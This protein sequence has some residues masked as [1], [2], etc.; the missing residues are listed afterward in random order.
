MSDVDR[1]PAGPGWPTNGRAHAAALAAALPDGLLQLDAATG[2]VLAVNPAAEALLGYEATALQ[3]Q[4]GLLVDRVH[5][6]DRARGRKLGAP[7]PEAPTRGR[8]R[9][10]RPDGRVSWLE[11]HGAVATDDT[12]L[13]VLREVTAAERERLLVAT[14]LVLQTTANRGGGQLESGLRAAGYHLVDHLDAGQLRIVTTEPADLD[15]TVRP[16]SVAVPADAPTRSEPLRRGTEEVGTLTVSWPPPLQPGPEQTERLR[17][18]ARELAGTIGQALSRDQLRLQRLVLDSTVNGVVVTDAQ[19][20]ILWVNDAI[21]TQTGFDRP[22]LIGAT[23]N[24]WRSGIHGPEVYRELWETVL[25]GDVWRGELVN[26]HAD[27]SLRLVRLTI[28]PIQ[29]DGEVEQL[30]AVHDDITEQRAAEEAREQADRQLR[31][32]L[33][34]L[35]VVVA[36]LDDEACIQRIDGA[37][38][39]VF[40]LDRDDL[41]GRPLA[42][43][44]PAARELTDALEAV[45][46]GGQV[47][48]VTRLGSRS[49]SL[50]LRPLQDRDER[51]P[52]TFVL[53]TDVT[54]REQ[55]VR[56]IRAARAQLELLVATTTDLMLLIDDADRVTYANPAG[57]LILGRPTDQLV[58]RSL[59]TLLGETE[60]AERSALARALDGGSDAT[61]HLGVQRPDGEHRHLD[62]VVADLRDDPGI[63]VAIL[64]GRDL[65]DTLRSAELRE[66]HRRQLEAVNAELAQASRARDDLL[67]VTSHELR[68]PLTPILGF[69]EMLLA[70]DDGSLGD[71][72]RHL[73]EV[74]GRNATRM[75]RLVDDLL[76]VS[77]L[78][79]GAVRADRHPTTLRRVVDEVVTTIGAELGTITVTGDAEVVADPEHLT[80]VLFNLLVN[81]RRYGA[82]PVELRIESGPAEVVVAVEDRGP[83]VPESFVPLMFDRF[84]QASTGDRRTAGG[85]GLGLTIVQALV[86]ANGGVVRYRR[87]RHAGACFEVVLPAPGQPTVTDPVAGGVQAAGEDAADPRR[88]HPDMPGTDDTAA[89]DTR[90]DL[91]PI[92]RAMA[93][94]TEELSDARTPAQLVQGLLHAV[95]SLGGWVVPADIADEHAL[96]LQVDLGVTSPM[97]VAAEVHHPARRLLEAHLP[98]LVVAAQA[99]LRG[100][101][102]DV[103]GDEPS[104]RGRLTGRR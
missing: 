20:T 59:W 92:T 84:A 18:A 1:R 76:L 74:I 69:V 21:L 58:G 86:A 31:S 80:R 49:V 54:A 51:P 55:A 15:L 85:S 10:L 44:L 67:S 25:A 95:R 43:L 77:R 100:L 101:Q 33:E 27:G 87:G 37:V 16:A 30:I 46:N 53:A 56:D 5:P 34:A 12:H 7:T 39:P 63:G 98:G 11:Q 104:G 32:V 96:P 4:P 94:A 52:G 36:S 71:E 3:Q 47:D 78:D 19:G 50:A 13:V 8:L 6:T 97:L 81:A 93:A 83:G 62:V 88:T 90:P 70:R 35:P 23:P 17:R 75:L 61:C 102:G 28:T 57:A 65:T 60:Q 68:T 91:D 45:R 48:L 9:W 24:I 64:V 99:R 72:R 73:L 38:V 26:R 79:A 2:D 66:A 14:R 40:G 42:S 29:S 22:R 89:D 103:P 41:L 82:P